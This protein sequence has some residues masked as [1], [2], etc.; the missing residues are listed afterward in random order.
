[1][2][3]LID[4]LIRIA[5]GILM[6]QQNIIAQQV[7][8]RMEEEIISILQS[9]IRD[10]VGGVWEGKGADAFVDAIN[11]EALPMAGQVVGH[12]TQFDTSLTQSVEIMDEADARTR[13]MVSNLEDT[14][15]SIY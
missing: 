8:A 11:T 3:D 14:F 1:M 12:V 4:K 10:V 7:L 2:S 13:S 6:Q 5:R 9:Y 15:T